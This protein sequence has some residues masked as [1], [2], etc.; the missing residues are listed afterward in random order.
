MQTSTAAMENSWR[1]LKKLEIELPYDPA[2][3]LL[4]KLT[5]FKDTDAGN[6]WRQEEKGMTEVAM[7]GWHHWLI[8]QEFEQTSSDGEV[9]E[10]LACCSPLSHSE[11]NRSVLLNNNSN[12]TP[13]S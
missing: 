13:V 10:S 3:P 7:V 1:F 9:Q 12:N 8:S 11:L 5:H 2:I 4:G 6:D